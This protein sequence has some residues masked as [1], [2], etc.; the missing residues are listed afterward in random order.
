ME[1]GGEHVPRDLKTG[2]EVSVFIFPEK[3]KKLAKFIALKF[4]ILIP[5]PVIKQ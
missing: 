5:L 3:K 4:L 2:K 1:L